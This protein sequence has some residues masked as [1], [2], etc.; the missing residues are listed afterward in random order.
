MLPPSGN[1]PGI[2]VPLQVFDRPQFVSPRELFAPPQSVELAKNH[3]GVAPLATIDSAAITPP[4]VEPPQTLVPREFDT[5]PTTHQPSLAIP[6]PVLEKSQTIPLVQPLLAPAVHE[7]HSLVVPS[8]ILESSRTVVPHHA[9]SPMDTVSP[10][11]TS[12]L[13]LGSSQP[14]PPPHPVASPVVTA[15]PS[16]VT[17]PSLGSSQ[18]VIT[19]HIPPTVTEPPLV[20]PHDGGSPQTVAP[21]VDASQKLVSRHQTID[22]SPQAAVAHYSDLAEGIVCENS[23]VTATAKIAYKPRGTST[24]TRSRRESLEGVPD[25]ILSLGGSGYE[26][27]APSSQQL[28]TTSVEDDMGTSA[29]PS[30]PLDELVVPSSQQSLEECMT[31]PMEVDTNT[32]ATPSADEL[33]VPSSQ[34]SLEEP[35][36]IPTTSVTATRSNTFAF[37]LRVIPKYNIDRSDFPSWLLE[38]GRLDRVLSVEGGK[39]WEKLITTWLRQERRLGFGLNERI[40][41]ENFRHAS[42]VF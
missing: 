38:R 25:I 8:L 35:L 20:T 18:L 10:L 42:S 6:S 22:P 23:E 12:S 41:S 16:L 2:S 5:S 36:T 33:I 34:Q 24:S 3:P 15:H 7:S 19:H 28:L 29:T 17:P 37:A 11:V 27:A 4:I 40:V 1:N 26:F 9:V 30:S 21:Q 13:T 14:S 32:P 31:I 39:I